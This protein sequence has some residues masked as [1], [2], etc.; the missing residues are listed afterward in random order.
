MLGGHGDKLSRKQEQAIAALLT[1]KTVEAAATKAGVAYSTL[2]GWLRKPA[3]RAAH[4]AAREQVLER[5]VARL[6]A[7]TSK[8]VETLEK[9]LDASAPRDSTRAAVAVLTHALKG[10]ELLDL[11]VRLKAL[12]DLVRER[13]H[14]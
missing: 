7:A 8:A 9:N 13:G 5:T 2:K 4:A 14:L 10:A 1:E 6:L 11:A 3:F 12:E